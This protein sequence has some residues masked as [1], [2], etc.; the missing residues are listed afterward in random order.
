MSRTFHSRLASRIALAATLAA[1]ALAAVAG[2]DVL[3]AALAQTHV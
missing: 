3:H 2:S 1:L